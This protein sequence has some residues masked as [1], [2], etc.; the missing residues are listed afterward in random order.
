MGTDAYPSLRARRGDGL[1]GPVDIRPARGVTS[2][3]I[4]I[5]SASGAFAQTEPTNVKTSIDPV[6]CELHIWPTDKFAV[7]ENLGGANLGLA[8]ALLDDAM[9]LKS[10]E[11]VAEQIKHQLDPVEQARIIKEVDPAALFR[12]SGYRV[13]IE[14]AADQPIWTL[15]RLKSDESIRK[16]HSACHAEMAIISQQYLHQAIGTRLR[17]LVW[18]REYSGSTPKVRVLDTT[19][20]KAADFPAERADRIPASTASVQAAFRE[21]LIKFA[22]DKLKR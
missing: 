1:M 2:L 13:V 22:K 11:G 10:P 17:T 20:T 7:T 21:N 15:D 18:Y 5:A 19:A 14:S 6:M 12:L 9:R 3:A 4:F 16:V 8:G